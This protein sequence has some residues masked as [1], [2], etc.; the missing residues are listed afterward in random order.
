MGLLALGP[1]AWAL[2]ERGAA[3]TAPVDAGS[4]LEVVLGLVVV[5][6]AIGASAWVLRYVLRFQPG[7]NGQLRVLAGL[8]MGPREKI[9]LLK[10]GD[11][12]L[13]VGVAPGRVHTL[14]VLERPLEEPKPASRAGSGFAA[15]LSHALR[16]PGRRQN[17]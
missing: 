14:H 2:P 12:Q 10:V 11:T 9:V 17:A 4:I 5:L 3:P 8:S 6:L 13:L 7:M 16:K 1:L 15:Q